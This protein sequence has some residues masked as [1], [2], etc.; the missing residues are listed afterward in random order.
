MLGTLYAVLRQQRL[1]WSCT[2]VVVL[3]LLLVGH[4]PVLPVL[5]GG[6]LALGLAVFRAWPH[7]SGKAVLRGGR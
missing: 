4:A 3:F 2:I 6:L 5:A 1:A 7:N